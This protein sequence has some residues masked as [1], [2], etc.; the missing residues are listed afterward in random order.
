MTA[1]TTNLNVIIKEGLSARK[2]RRQGSKA[3]F[4]SDISQISH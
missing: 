3:E 4:C 1:G 2:S